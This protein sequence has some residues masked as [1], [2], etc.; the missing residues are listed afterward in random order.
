MEYVYNYSYQLKDCVCVKGDQ[1]QCMMV[2]L[3]LTRSIYRSAENILLISLNDIQ[4]EVLLSHL[5]NVSI[6]RQW[7]N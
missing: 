2:T 4:A 7:D 1:L 3:S 5:L 6:T